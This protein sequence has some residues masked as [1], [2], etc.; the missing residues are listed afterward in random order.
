MGQWGHMSFTSEETA[1]HIL[2]S[3]TGGRRCLCSATAGITEDMFE[4]T[5][6]LLLLRPLYTSW[7]HRDGLLVCYS[8]NPI[9]TETQFAFFHRM[10]LCPEW[11]GSFSGAEEE[12]HDMWPL[13]HIT[14]QTDD[15]SVCVCKIHTGRKITL[16]T[17]MKQWDTVNAFELEL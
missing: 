12:Q 9:M 17:W 14:S 13:S 6:S 3:Q 5:S 10:V 11:C 2:Q 7:C 15:T 4:T 1:K 8:T 16:W